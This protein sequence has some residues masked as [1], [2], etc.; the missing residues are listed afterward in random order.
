MYFF[1]KYLTLSQKESTLVLFKKATI[2]LVNELVEVGLTLK[3]AK[4][5]TATLE[6]KQASILQIAKK[7]GLNRSVIYPLLPRMMQEGF[8]SISYKGARRVYT[9][10]PPEAVKEILKKR[11][12]KFNDL[13]P[14]LVSLGRTSEVKPRIRYA[15]GLEGIKDAYRNALT[16]K[17]SVIR[18]FVGIERLYS[19]SRV[20]ENFWERE[21]V[22]GRM[23]NKKQALLV[24]PDNDEGR[25]LRT[26]SSEANREVK[27]VPAS[28]YNFENEILIYDSTVVIFSYSRGEHYALEIESATIAR[29]MK[30]IWQMS[31]N[32]G[33]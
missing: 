25:E 10:E 26:S 33:Y 6:L 4:I 20:L 14:E 21:F 22:P 23:R 19:E 31:W 1:T 8:L 2:M 32:M 5:Y 24:V 9:A 3:E 7:T 30:M 12:K 28:Q 16:A 13:L 18:A 17:E 29:T 15:E 27:M 11:I